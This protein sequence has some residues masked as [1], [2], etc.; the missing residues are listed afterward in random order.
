MSSRRLGSHGCFLDLEHAAVGREAD[1][2][3]L[4]QIAQKSPHAEVVGVVD[5]G[6]GTQ[7]RTAP[8]S[9]VTPAPALCWVTSAAFSLSAGTALATATGRPQISRKA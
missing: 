8:A 4:G 7:A 3:Q 1:L 6:F 2:A 5:G 9:S